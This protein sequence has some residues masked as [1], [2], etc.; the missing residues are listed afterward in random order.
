MVAISHLGLDGGLWRPYA[1][2]A[3]K[4]AYVSP[5]GVN[6]FHLTFADSSEYGTDSSGGANTL[7]DSGGL[8]TSDQLG[9]VPTNNYMTLNP[10][11]SGGT[12]SDGG[13]NDAGGSSVNSHSIALPTT[14]KWVWEMTATDIN[15]ST[16]TSH[17]FGICDARVPYSASFS[18]HEAISAFTQRGGELEKNGTGTSTGTAIVDTDVLRFE[19]DADGLTLDIFVDGAQSGSQ[20]TGLTDVPYKVWANSASG[21]L[22]MNWN[23]GQLA[24]NGTPSAGYEALSNAN[25]EEAQGD[26]AI[27]DPTAQFQTTLYTGNGTA[28]GSGGK[29]VSQVEASTFQPDLVWIKGRSGAT[30]HVLTDVIR[31]VTEELNPNDTTVE[32]TVAEGLT[33]FGAAGFTVGSDGSYNTSSATYT[34]WQWLADNTTGETLSG[35]DLDSVVAANQAAGFSIAKFTVVTPATQTFQHGLSQAPGLVIARTIGSAVSWRVYH[36]DLTSAGYYLKLNN[37]DAQS[38]DAVQ[39]ASTAPSST[40]I[41]VGGGFAAGDSIAYSFH[42]VEGYSKIGSYEGNGSTDGPY[43]SCGFRPAFVI[44]KNIDAGSTNWDMFDNQRPGYNDSG[45]Q[46]PANLS[47]AEPASPDHNINFTSDG[48]KIRDASTSINTNAQTYVYMAIAESP[49][50]RSNAR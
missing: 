39:W 16:A 5:W 1:S 26:P 46:L 37:T 40:L 45:Y 10:L 25:I 47:N 11:D 3:G 38:L 44:L 23:F 32:E 43:V 41:T 35:G 19:F 6:G 49:G 20:I 30:E 33:T 29:A 48:F 42:S 34:A 9:D 21:S 2:T 12:I 24:F 14:G 36:K 4:S 28:I 13:L 27:L 22:D 31:G 8:D 18:D 7:A 50:T 17:Y 15:T